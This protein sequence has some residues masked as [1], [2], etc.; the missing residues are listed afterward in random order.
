MQTMVSLDSYELPL[1]AADPSLL[2]SLLQPRLALFWGANTPTR[3]LLASLAVM[4][5]QG[6]HVRVYDGGN[7]FDGYFITRLARRLS[8]DPHAT[9]E[10]IRL[11]RA[12]T[13]F[14]KLLGN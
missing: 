3:A 11:S 9:L 8:S 2:D 7:R 14:H 12:F 6:H 10:R 5:A 4:A 1:P 13:C